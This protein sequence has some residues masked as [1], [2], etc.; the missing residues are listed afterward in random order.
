MPGWIQEKRLSEIVTTAA[1]EDWFNNLFTTKKC[2][3]FVDPRIFPY[4][5]RNDVKHDELKQLT[6]YLWTQYYSHWDISKQIFN[7][8]MNILK[9]SD[10]NKRNLIVLNSYISYVESIKIHINRY[11]I[12]NNINI[13]YALPIAI[14]YSSDNTPMNILFTDEEI[15]DEKSVYNLI[16][17]EVRIGIKIISAKQEWW[18]E[19][20]HKLQYDIKNKATDNANDKGTPS[21][22]YSVILPSNTFS[23]DVDIP[24][25]NSKANDDTLKQLKQQYGEQYSEITKQYKTSKKEDCYF[26]YPIHTSSFNVEKEYQ[27]SPEHGTVH[28][29]F[30][31]SVF[32]YTYSNAIDIGDILNANITKGNQLLWAP[33]MSFSFVSGKEIIR[34]N[35]K[36]FVWLRPVVK[37]IKPVTDKEVIDWFNNEISGS[38][39]INKDI[40]TKWDGDDTLEILLND[41]EQ[42]TLTQHLW[43]KYE[44][45]FMTGS[46]EKKY[47]DRENDNLVNQDNFNDRFQQILT[48]DKNTR[49]KWVGDDFK[50]HVY[51]AIEKIEADL[52][53]QSQLK[54]KINKSHVLAIA[55]YSS[56]QYGQMN[57]FARGIPNDIAED[58][59]VWFTCKA[60]LG[61]Q[62][63]GAIQNWVNTVNKFN[64]NT[65]FFSKLPVEIQQ[66]L[67]DKRV[68]RRDVGF[69]NDNFFQKYIDAFEPSTSH[70]D[71]QLEFV[72]QALLSSSRKVEGAEPFNETSNICVFIIVDNADPSE[73]MDIKDT[74]AYPLEAEILWRPN[75]KFDVVYCEDTRSM[76]TFTQD[77]CDTKLS[78]HFDNDW[79]NWKVGKR[80]CSETEKVW[81]VV[82][83]TK[84]KRDE[85][86]AK[87]KQQ[88]DKFFHKNEQ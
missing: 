81:L 16:M 84:G 13:K 15:K 4:W 22:R 65:D 80:K 14:Y 6:D 76:E 11:L 5:E 83:A 58:I 27:I 32:N 57:K 72:D 29:N 63:L 35:N 1:I 69:M 56:S 67:K 73:A 48:G 45:W 3:N 34:D 59:H 62:K 53:S 82:E 18:K 42:N 60:A 43:E 19:E 87:L 66:K 20:K 39:V 40:I 8:I 31:I 33:N 71:L 49:N 54:G 28:V 30:L 7:D 41:A 52:P 26:S 61:I 68:L 51:T 75:T 2:G 70:T 86:N 24:Y 44:F 74:S 78:P 85:Y 46:K 21:V 25:K 9:K 77:N 10:G 37:G 79:D 64:N 12:Q 36:A 38:T 50:H 23:S 47:G 88:Y 17:I 55:I